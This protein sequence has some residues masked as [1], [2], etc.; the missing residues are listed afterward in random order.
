M[1]DRAIANDEV[2]F[3]GGIGVGMNARRAEREPTRRSTCRCHLCESGESRY[4]TRCGVCDSS[5][6]VDHGRIEDHYMDDL[7]NVRCPG[8]GE[9]AS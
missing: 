6:E 8:S 5:V 3:D 2:Y 1:G 7:P 9:D 4:D